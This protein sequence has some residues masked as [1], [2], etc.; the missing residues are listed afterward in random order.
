MVRAYEYWNGVKYTGSRKSHFWRAPGPKIIKV[1]ASAG[2]ASEENLADL[3]V[4][5]S[6]SMPKLPS[7]PT[8]C[9]IFIPWRLCRGVQLHPLEYCLTIAQHR[10]CNFCVK[11]KFQRRR[12][13]IVAQNRKRKNSALDNDLSKSIVIFTKSIV[14]NTLSIFEKYII[15]DGFFGMKKKSFYDPTSQVQLGRAR[16]LQSEGVH[17]W[18]GVSHQKP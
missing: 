14:Q 16:V 2:G 11:S 4:R 5:S 6:Q 10:T 18:R 8:H 1:F 17:T 15:D 3:R 7:N 9:Y 13:D 12:I